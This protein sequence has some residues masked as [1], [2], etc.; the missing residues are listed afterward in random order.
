MS[1]IK[2][3]DTISSFIVSAIQSLLTIFFIEMLYRGGFGEAFQWTREYTRPFTYNFLLLFL[4][5]AGLHIFKRKMY[6]VVSFIVTIPLLF[7]GLAS[8]I[9]QGIR[10]VPVLPTDLSL[11]AEARSMA[12]FFSGTLLFWTIVGLITLTIL[13]IMLV[14]KV[15]NPKGH[16]KTKLISSLVLLVLFLLIFRIESTSDTS[17]LKRNLM[18]VYLMTD[19]KLTYQQD[20]VIGGFVQNLKWLKQEKPP[21]YSA[22]AVK[23]IISK[24]K[25]AANAP[26]T[27]KP[28]II[29]IMNEAFWDPTVMENVEFNKDPLPFYHQ[30]EKEQSS[31]SL[32]VTV[33]G[34]STVNTEFEALTGLSTQFLP[35]GSIAYLN[36]VKKPL[37]SLPSILRE[38]GYD[39]TAIHSWHH[40]FYDRSGVYEDL[41]FDRFISVEYMEEPLAF[42]PFFHDKTVTDEILK[43]LERDNEGKPNFIFAVTTQNHGPYATDQKYSFANIETQLK[44]NAAFSDEAENMLEVYSDNLTEIDKEL[45]RLVE[46]V[47]KINQKT[48]IVLFGDHLPL[49]GNNYQV[50]QEANYYNDT[51]TY[52]E[53]LKMYTTPVLIWDNFSDRQDDL[54]IGSTMLTPVILERAGLSG[55]YLTNYLLTKYQSG[56][57][58]KIPRA[59]FLAEEKIDNQTLNELKMLQYDILFGKMYG[60]ED[61]KIEVSK[62]YRLGYSD[63]KVTGIS[64]STVDG[65]K[66]LI[67]KGKNFTYNS[68]VYM[69]G[70]AA[71]KI[72]SDATKIIIPYSK[73]KDGTE[74]IVKITDQN[75]KVLSSS[76]KYKYKKS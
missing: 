61:K 54:N 42:G 57:F 76:N 71:G 46:E 31:G 30:L 27:E 12:E 19:Q 40:W 14:L 45:Q 65:K 4:L 47:N 16:N 70:K 58:S 69:N 66:V 25:V 1:N 7:L 5:L 8:Y 44:G 62:N 48:I 50:Y 41:G 13:I 43:K 51:K 74:I 38:Q 28:N 22:S 17:F 63:P 64:T 52:E 2:I 72:S 59:D 53:Y 75:E 10:G 49:L 11:A 20:G 29:M 24:S 21:G 68:Y 56:E 35:T 34:G 9:K 73:I 26:D 23:E 55:N 33:F 39:T 32:N 6:I 60:M 18:I 36:F 3:K 37:P 15:P 67:I